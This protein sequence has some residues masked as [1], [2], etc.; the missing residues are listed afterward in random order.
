M[1]LFE[2]QRCQTGRKSGFRKKTNRNSIDILKRAR[3]R[4]LAL[5]YYT[6]FDLQKALFVR[7]VQLKT[8]AALPRP[9][10]NIF[11]YCL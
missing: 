10:S 3:K 7:S 2:H 4:R 1:K 5:V 11:V 9:L 8:C 6:C